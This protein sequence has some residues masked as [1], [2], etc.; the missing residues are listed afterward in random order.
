MRNL[1]KH[2]K[3]NDLKYDY[4]VSLENGLSNEGGFFDFCCCAIDNNE[5]TLKHSLLPSECTKVPSE[6]CDECIRLEQKI[7][8]GEVIER[9]KQVSLKIVG[10]KILMKMD[11]LELKSCMIFSVLH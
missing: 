4:C 2:L 10:M 9:K 3:D 7:T 6:Y 5:I 11:L 1:R 8:I